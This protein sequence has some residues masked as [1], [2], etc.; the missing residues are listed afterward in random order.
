VAD[1]LEAQFVESWRSCWASMGNALKSRV[2]VLLSHAQPAT[3]WVASMTLISRGQG[4]GFS[5][6]RRTEAIDSERRDR[7]AAGPPAGRRERKGVCL[8]S[9]LKGARWTWLL[10]GP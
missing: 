5:S 10:A 1:F 7:G 6:R 9:S 3:V 2:T 8:G 4:G